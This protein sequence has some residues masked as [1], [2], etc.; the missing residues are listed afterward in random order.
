MC[1]AAVYY[2]NSEGIIYH[3]GLL[4]FAAKKT[5]TLLILDL[6]K[7]TYVTER[8]GAQFTGKGSFNAQP[9][10]I[11]LGNYKRWI[12]FSEDGGG[13]PGVYVRNKDGTYHTIFEGIE[14]GVYDGDETGK[15]FVYS[16]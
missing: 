12:Y 13:S 7:M 3:E 11:V 5:Q 9:D 1:L 10:Q 6:E 2:K 14:G 15:C 4:Y 16:R 8:T